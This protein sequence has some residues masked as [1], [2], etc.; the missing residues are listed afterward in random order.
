M[1][2]LDEYLL[3]YLV[4]CCSEIF[5]EENTVFNSFTVKTSFPVSHLSHAYIQLNVTEQN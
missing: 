3:K 4:A 2:V 1:R 5:Q